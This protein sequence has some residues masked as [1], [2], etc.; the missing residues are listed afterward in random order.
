[1]FESLLWFNMSDD[2]V[3]FIV[4]FIKANNHNSY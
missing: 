1:V 4:K 3:G 2:S